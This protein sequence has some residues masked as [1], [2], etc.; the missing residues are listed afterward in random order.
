MPDPLSLQALMELARKYTTPPTMPVGYNEQEERPTLPERPTMFKPQPSIIGTD[1]ARSFERLRKILPDIG[2]SNTKSIQFGPGA[3]AINVLMRGG[4][5]PSDYDRS[6]IEGTFKASTGTIDLNPSLRGENH[7]DP[8]LAHELS[9]AA[10]SNEEEARSV[11][12]AIREI[13]WPRTPWPKK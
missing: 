4:L 1:A 3:G 2:S 5:N 13:R 8:I 9:H 7:I 11:E 12:K 10:G 6:N